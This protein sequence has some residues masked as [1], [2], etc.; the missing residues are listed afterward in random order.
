[1]KNLEIPGNRDLDLKIPKKSPVENPEYPQD[2]NLFCSEYPR[3][4][5]G[6]GYPDKKP[7]LI[8]QEIF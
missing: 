5:R 3:D 6:M 4:F 2:R 8:F 1:M 7:T